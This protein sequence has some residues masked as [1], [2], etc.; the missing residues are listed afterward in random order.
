MIPL[1]ARWVNTEMLLVFTPAIP[2]YLDP[3]VQPHGCGP[4]VVVDFDDLGHGAGLVEDTTSQ[5]AADDARS[6]GNDLRES[7]GGLEGSNGHRS[8][9]VVALRVAFHDGVG[10][11]DEP[12]VQLGWGESCYGGKT[13]P[14]ADVMRPSSPSAP[15]ESVAVFGQSGVPRRTSPTFRDPGSCV[16]AGEDGAAEDS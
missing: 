7:F 1:S 15:V 5:Q 12:V 10:L 3:R 8:H 16:A 4:G 6:G 14:P 11:V 2:A 9:Q 13:Q